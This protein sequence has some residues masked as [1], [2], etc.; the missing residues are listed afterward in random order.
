MEE[1][2]KNL[3]IKQGRL[4][5]FDIIIIVILLFAISLATI[6]MVPKFRSAADSGQKSTIQ[7]TV[8]FY[9]VDEAV[10]DKIVVG[11]NVTDNVSGN[12]LGIVDDTPESEI[13]YKYVLVKDTENGDQYYAQRKDDELGRRNVTVTVVATA[14]YKEG[15]GY[16]VEGYG[17][18]VGKEMNLRFPDF[19][20]IG[21]CDSLTVIS[22]N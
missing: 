1:N 20:A 3:K 4:N 7:Y 22:E 21:Y 8:V 17:I 2:K 5:V 15:E 13:S 16:L 18:S 14:T 11:V 19:C 10:Y 12:S 6:F 9:N